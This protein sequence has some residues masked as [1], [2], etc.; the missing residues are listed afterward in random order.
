[1]LLAEIPWAGRV[2]ALPF[3]TALAASERACRDQG[4]RHKTLPGVGRQLARQAR[5]WLP[6]RD[7]VR[8]ADSSFAALAF[9]DTVQRGGVSV[10][11]RLR[12]DAAL[13]DPA[14][15]RLPGR[16]GRPRKK[17]A[18]QPSLSQRLTD[19]NTA[20][21]HVCVPGWYGTGPRTIALA[22][23][24]AVW[25]R[26]GLPVVPLRWVLIRDPHDAFAPQALLCTDTDRDPALIVSCLI[27]SLSKDRAALERRGHLPG[28]AHPSGRRDPAAVVAKGHRPHHALPARPVLDRHPARR[29][30]ASPR[31]TGGRSCGLVP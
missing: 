1:M 12:L 11:T 15:P 7:R 27:L 6:G 17:G 5:R 21:T 16:G 4:R 18:R 22:S 25:H 10:V 28:G 20:W 31:T 26:D 8:V 23:A 14:P 3:L 29:P 19:P 2:W 9:L 24:T 13:Y 30:A